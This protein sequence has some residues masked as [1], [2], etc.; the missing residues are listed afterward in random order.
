MALA[1][2]AVGV[3]SMSIVHALTALTFFLL[4][5]PR[6]S[7]FVSSPLV[8][9]NVMTIYSDGVSGAL[10]IVRLATQWALGSPV[11]LFVM[12]MFA[13][14]SWYTSNNG[15]GSL[16]SG[17]ADPGHDIYYTAVHRQLQQVWHLFRYAYDGVIGLYNYP[18]VATSLFTTDLYE[19]LSSCGK[20]V[21]GVTVV[22]TTFT[23]ITQ[24]AASLL[25]SSVDF[26]GNVTQASL[27]V[28]N[29]TGYLQRVPAN[30][31]L[32]S[33]CACTQF[34]PLVAAS[35]RILASVTMVEW[36]NSVVNIPIRSLQLPLNWIGISDQD[37]S[38]QPAPRAFNL[39]P[40]KET[41]QSATH[42]TGVVLDD[43]FEEYTRVMLSDAFGIESDTSITVP[44]PFVGSTLALCG[45][46]LLEMMENA[47]AV[48][49]FILNPNDLSTLPKIVDLGKPMDLAHQCVYGTA[50][51]SQFGYD[52]VA[53]REINDSGLN[54]LNCPTYELRIPGRTEHQS[55]RAGNPNPRP[56][57]STGSS[58]VCSVYGIGRAGLGL[59]YTPLRFWQDLI[60]GG[61]LTDFDGLMEFVRDY[62]GGFV[63]QF[64]DVDVTLDLT[65]PETVMAHDEFTGVA[66]PSFARDVIMPLHIG[67]FY[68]PIFGMGALHPTFV[69]RDTIAAHVYYTMRLF[70]IDSPQTTA[71]TISNLLE[72]LYHGNSDDNPFNK[73]FSRL[74][75]DGPPQFCMQPGAE[76]YCYKQKCIRFH[77]DGDDST[78]QKMQADEKH[79]WCGAM[80]AR[81]VVDDLVAISQTFGTLLEIMS[82]GFEREARCQTRIDSFGRVAWI[83][84]MFT[85]DGKMYGV[86][87]YDDWAP[88]ANSAWC[89]T[90]Y[91]DNI[92]CDA[93]HYG[94]NNAEA[95]A[96]IFY[97]YWRNFYTVLVLRDPSQ[98]DL[99]LHNRWCEVTKRNGFVASAAGNVVGS[100]VPFLAP[101]VRGLINLFLDQ[102]PLVLWLRDLQISLY[103][104]NAVV[105]AGADVENFLREY[106]IRKMRLYFQY[107]THYYA[108]ILA[109]INVLI[110]GEAA[111]N[112]TAT[113]YI[114][115][116]TLTLNNLGKALGAPFVL[117][118][119]AYASLVFNC[120]LMTV[121]VGDSSQCDFGAIGRVLNAVLD[122]IVPIFDQVIGFVFQLLGKDIG[123]ILAI[124]ANTMCEMIKGLALIFQGLIGSVVIPTV[125]IVDGLVE[126]VNQIGGLFGR[127]RLEDND[128]QDYGA[129]L[130]YEV[131][132]FMMDVGT[133][134]YELKCPDF[135][136]PDIDE[137]GDDFMSAPA[138]RPVPNVAAAFAHRRRRSERR[139]LYQNSTPVPAPV[140][141]PVPAPFVLDDVEM[142]SFK[143]LHE[144]FD[145]NGDTVCAR[146]G[147][148]GT[149]PTSAYEK[150]Q[151]NTCVHNRFKVMGL[152]TLLDLPYTFLDSWPSAASFVARLGIGLLLYTG[153]TTIADLD[154][155]G[156]PGLAVHQ[157]ST[158]AHKAA[159]KLF[160]SMSLNKTLDTFGVGDAERKM[161]VRS[162]AKVPARSDWPTRD[163]AVAL[164]H[165]LNSSYH[166][167]R[168]QLPS[169]EEVK[170][171]VPAPAPSPA[172]LVPDR[173]RLLFK[174]DSWP[175]SGV[176][177]SDMYS[178][179]FHGDCPLITRP[180]RVLRDVGVLTKRHYDAYFDNT[181]E[182]AIAVWQ[183]LQFDSGFTAIFDYSD[184]TYVRTS[185]ARLRPP[186]VSR[187]LYD[188]RSGNNSLSK[189]VTWFVDDL[190]PRRFVSRLGE[191]FTSRGGTNEVF[192]EQLVQW[193]G[194]FL[195]RC[196]YQRM[197]YASCDEPHASIDD[198]YT[199]LQTTVFTSMFVGYVTGFPIL[200]ALA[201]PPVVA[202][203]FLDRRYDYAPRCLPA[204]PVCVARD[205][206]LLW[207]EA[208]GVSEC[209]CQTSVGAALLDRSNAANVQR[210]QDCDYWRRPSVFRDR[211]EPMLYNSCPEHNIPDMPYY[212]MSVSK[213][214]FPSI[215]K[216]VFNSFYSPLR[217]VTD[218]STEVQHMIATAGSYSELERACAILHIPDFI[219]VLLA[220]S[221]VFGVTLQLVV[222][223]SRLL[224][225]I[226][227]LYYTL[228]SAVF[229]GT[230]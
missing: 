48:I 220:V 147:Q 107:T 90:E 120:L 140:P 68:L 141:P 182:D 47:N 157:V 13:M 129:G 150:A 218:M 34:Q 117:L 19:T 16:V 65:S 70:L 178:L 143:F 205:A 201:S 57:D 116:L 151:F 59:F 212:F 103:S 131:T 43:V 163:D 45:M 98:L 167:L 30:L 219:I 191:F 204:M 49:R 36:V 9:T 199:Y 112:P 214:W 72:G 105:T 35:A 216:V 185:E 179:G 106:L 42:Y 60:F 194:R 139:R 110:N 123:N 100:V 53:G 213:I 132:K 121:F 6:Q 7:T 197:L 228:G 8:V 186:D 119:E 138:P 118:V 158:G 63:V 21:D 217:A 29:A 180:F 203:V 171:W 109:S 87:N 58:L 99:F 5:V 127:R 44:R 37:A 168:E 32:L 208:F 192:G 227:S 11:R 114:S 74:Q 26:L 52:L 225:G 54:T 38:S 169:W 154:N 142:K 215:F 39:R 166:T 102:S 170:R 230:S 187:S 173:R 164:G 88:I 56:L 126:V 17:F 82:T 146:I 67:I 148:L 92:G 69:V 91:T 226:F 94:L 177:I 61:K 25:F 73:P 115:K 188:P 101:R 15:E 12:F 181:T 210:C 62:Q 71:Y 162:W 14:L 128:L 77:Y 144:H 172:P 224:A 31:E 46:G 133:I 33:T 85:S 155:K 40:L 221:L 104:F 51:V 113:D 55:I 189:G 223:M 64:E 124:V 211:A 23:S 93:Y 176:N 209:F 1:A 83:N 152:R 165:H 50:I 134:T 4:I 184:P 78:L 76:A 80:L 75:V 159:S 10:S 196:D 202:F 174:D 22:I 175:T 79:F 18:I 183:S 156:L 95:L 84:Q 3:V 200:A 161:L 97:Q 108:K 122:S 27:D 81:P 130:T 96:N 149:P 24:A 2:F 28:R 125:G 222:T 190:T 207:N 41:L 86:E 20:D 206:H 193:L 198:L 153:N 229:Y 66:H 137:A 195:R 135:K 160:Y 145:W 111:P 89:E 136:P